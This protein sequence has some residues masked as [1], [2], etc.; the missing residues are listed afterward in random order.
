MGEHRALRPAR[1][2]APPA[3][4]LAL[5]EQ[6]RAVLGEA[7]VTVDVGERFRLCHLAALRAGAAVLAVRGRPAAARR[8]LVSVWLLLESVAPEYADWAR[9]FAAGAPL[10]AAVE[11]GARH[12]VSARQADDQYRAAAQFLHLVESDLGLLAAPLAS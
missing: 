6:A 3:D 1:P 10:R 2:G 5:A 7:A 12:A 4:A 11:A 9:H 8:R